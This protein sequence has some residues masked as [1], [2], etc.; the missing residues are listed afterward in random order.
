MA[1]RTAQGTSGYTQKG[2]W[3]GVLTAITADML[4]EGTHLADHSG[5]KLEIVHLTAVDNAETLA[6]GPGIFAV[7]WQPEDPTDD[8]VRMALTTAATGT[9]T[10]V[11]SAASAGW[12]WILRNV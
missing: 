5:L 9:V 4:A 2:V 3:G 10:F 1:S 7:A 6:L 8:D 11:A 12:V